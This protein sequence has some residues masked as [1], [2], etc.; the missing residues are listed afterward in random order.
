MSR[1]KKIAILIVILAIVAMAALRAAQV[2]SAKKDEPKR[3]G[4]LQAPLVEAAPVT[5]GLLEEKIS[6]TGDIAPY[7]QVTIFSK[8][9]GWVEKIN[10]REGDRVKVGQV[11][12]AL[13][14]REAEATVAQS[15]ANLEAATARLKQVRATSEEA[16]QSQIQHTRATLE[17]AES[18]L[19]RARELYE[20]NFIARQQMDEAQTKYNVARAS[21]DLAQNSLRQRIWE[22]DI[23]LAEAQV[24]QALA[25]LELTQAQ[26]ANL[27]ILSPMNGEVN[28]RHVDPGT[29]VKD[30]TPILTLMDLNQ[31][32]MVVN[33]IEKEFVQLQ[34]G[35][36]VK[37][38]VSAFPDRP[39]QGRIS[40]IPPALELQSRTAEIQITIPNPGYVL[41]PG[42][43]GQ[44]EI[45]LRFDPKAILAP[46]QAMFTEGGMDYVFVLKDGKAIRRTVRK[47]LTRDTQVEIIQGL[48]P[49]EQ[50]IIASPSLLKDGMPVRLAVKAERKE[51][52]KD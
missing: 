19:K 15:R 29:M 20:K 34:K 50:V 3:Q 51:E 49:G 46:I 37:V 27:I 5:Q 31:V 30:T 11:L 38:T 17:L 28:K 10:V 8:V 2:I 7:A 45:I 47:G 9:Q 26:L 52:T 21:Y 39:F 6:R 33:V 36:G 42:M 41:K 18:D 23:A 32:K 44:V 40:I 16:V 24:R 43:F 12:A 25:N 4:G 13:D 22:N 1:A 35:Q 14:I 48:S